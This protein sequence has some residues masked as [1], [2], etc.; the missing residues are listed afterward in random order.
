M[1]IALTLSRLANALLPDGW[2]VVRVSKTSGIPVATWNRP[3]DEGS[4]EGVNFYYLG[5]DLALARMKNGLYLYLDPQDESVGAHLITRGYWEN[6]VYSVVCH[7]VKP[8]DHVVEVGANFGY[9]TTA[10]ARLVGPEGRITTLE[11]N[12]HL[13][14]L[15]WK[16]LNFNN[17]LARVEI[18]AKAASDQ[19]G[20]AAF[21]SS[22]SNAGGGSTLPGASPEDPEITIVETVRL[23]DVVQGSPRVIRIDAEGSELLILRGAE[24]LLQRPDVVICMEWD[25]YQMASRGDVNAFADWLS[26]LGFRFWRIGYDSSL[27]EVQASALPETTQCDLVV[28]RAY[29]IALDDLA[30]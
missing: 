22:R 8:G 27:V 30:A 25:I 6:W 23:D 24:R 19:A 12:T 15:I 21:R 17:F 28:A 11:A 2:R 3:Q 10:M 26:S 20:T 9:Y 29:P 18:I 7:I 16:S 13:A 5:P 4:Q 14:G 1:S